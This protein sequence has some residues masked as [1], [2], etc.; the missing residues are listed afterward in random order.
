MNAESLDHDHE[1][2]LDTPAKPNPAAPRKPRVAFRVV[3]G[4]LLVVGM[5]SG[6]AA[7]GRQKAGKQAEAIE[8]LLQAGARVYFDYQWKQGSP[9]ADAVPPEAAWVRRLLGDDMLNRAV[10]VDLR[11]VE[12]PDTVANSLLL[13][14]YL[15][16]VNAANT[17]LSDAALDVLRRMPGLTELD[18]QGTRITD[19]SSTNLA[20]VTQLTTLSL[21]RTTISDRSLPILAGLQHLQRLDLSGTPVTIAPLNRF[22]TQLPKCQVLSSDD[23]K[24]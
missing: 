11:G 24:T 22:R 5:L 15:Y 1:N 10:A 2:P 23:G 6:W 8:R 4:I 7:M 12:Q 9:V 3:L 17:P 14:P 19:A 16:H 21:A 13:L 20:R 18:L